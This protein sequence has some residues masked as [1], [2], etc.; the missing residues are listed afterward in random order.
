MDERERSIIA[1]HEVGHAICGKVH[2]DK[3]KVEEISLFAHGEALGVTVSSQEDN[4]LPSESD[5]RARLVALMGGR[6]AEELLFHEVTGGASNDFEKANQ[7]ATTMVTQWGMG[8]DPEATDGGIVR[9]RLALVP[10][11]DRRAV[12]AVRG[13]GRGDAGDP[14]DPRR[15]LRRGAAA[16]LVAHIEHAAP[17]RRLPRRA[18]AG[19]RRHVRRAVRRPAGRREGRRRVARRR[20]R[21]RAT[22]ATSWTSRRGGSARRSSPRPCRSRPWRARPRSRRLR[23]AVAVERGRDLPGGGARGAA[24]RDLVGRDRV[25]RVDRGTSRGAGP[26]R[27]A[28]R[29]GRRRRR[30]VASPQRSSPDRALAA[31]PSSA[32]PARPPPACSV[33]R[34][35]GSAPASWRPTGSSARTTCA[36]RVPSGGATRSLPRALT[37]RYPGGVTALDGLTV[38][39]EPG[40]VGLVGSNGAGKSTLIKILLGLHRPDERLGDGLRPRRRGRRAPTSA[41]SSATCPSTTACRRTAS[42]TDVVSHLAQMSGLPRTAARER[43]AEVLRHVGPVRGA[44]PGDRRLLDRDEAAGQA[45]PGARPRPA[46]AAPRRADERPRPGRP[47]RDAR[48]DPPNRHASSGSRSSSPRTSSARSSGSATTSSRSRAASSCGRR[49]SASFTERTGTLAVEV[50]DGSDALAARLAAAGLSTIVDGRAVLIASS[51]SGRTT[52]SATRSRT[53]ACRSSGSSSGGT[54]SRTCSATRRTDGAR[55]RCHRRSGASAA[56]RARR[57]RPGRRHDR[58][59]CPSTARP[60]RSTTSAIA[61]TTGPRLG[62]ALRDPVAVHRTAS[63]RPTASAGGGRAKIAPF[64]LGWSSRSCRRSS[65]LGALDARRPVRRPVERARRRELADPLRHVFSV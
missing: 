10:R 29:A 4:D 25:R 7:I 27:D 43:T 23:T 41:S 39:I 52:S 14:G 37:K 46:A 17:A 1:A 48:A 59:R 45:R 19:R 18:R 61:A 64:V 31:G 6:A 65:I 44:L 2:G 9:P 35:A 38:D 8:R 55:R 13:P 26:R 21:G 20:R 33:A 32:R 50:E 40:I 63:G 60:A 56:A 15:R 42:A 62:R 3:R 22:G 11:P 24:G 5:L 57:R 47:R 53:S 54:A 30:S 28:R 49:R 36:P 51:T 12:A 16:T 34:S 58:T